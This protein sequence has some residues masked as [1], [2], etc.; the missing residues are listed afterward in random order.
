[1]WIPNWMRILHKTPLLTDSWT[2]LKYIKRWFT[3]VLH[4]N[5]FSSIWRTQYIWSAIDLLR[6]N[7]HW[8]SPIT[9]S[10]YGVIL[11]SRMLDKILIVLGYSDMSLKLL[12]SVLSPFSWIGTIIDPFHSSGNSSLFQI[13]IISL[14]I[15][16]RI[17]LRPALISSAGIWSIPGDLWFF[18]FSIANST[19]KALGS[20][21]FPLAVLN[22]ML[23]S[24]KHMSWYVKPWKH[25]VPQDPV[26]KK[27]RIL[28]FKTGIMSS[29]KSSLWKHY[30][31]E[32]LKWIK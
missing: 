20:M 28:Y 25:W 6:Q 21:P 18:S 14:W 16:Q 13:E 4:S 1:M 27:E 30:K 19:S 7:P 24:D 23:I 22:F 12:Q 17:V 29:N 32:Y 15:A 11:D 8:W 2:S 5:F 26:K 3:V 31:L 9:S 10:A